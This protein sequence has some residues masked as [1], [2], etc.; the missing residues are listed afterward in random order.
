MQP[1]APTGEARNSVPSIGRNAGSRG[2]CGSR[3]R[4]IGSE[5]AA[6][7]TAP[8]A[9][10]VQ[11]VGLMTSRLRVPPSEASRLAIM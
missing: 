5:E 9:S 7:V 4:T 10:A 8:S 11:R 3:P 1:V 6:T 2:G